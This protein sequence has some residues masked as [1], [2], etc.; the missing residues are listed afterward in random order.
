MSEQYI[1]FYYPR[2]GII[3]GGAQLLYA[4]II[5]YISKNTKL[6]IRLYDYENGC[7]RQLLKN[8]NVNNYE[9]NIIKNDFS[10]L[11]NGG[12]E[13]FVIAPCYISYIANGLKCNNNVRFIFWDLLYPLWEDLISI[14]FKREKIIS[15]PNIREK[16]LITMIN[17]H[18][19]AILPEGLNYFEKLT[20]QQIEED[21]ILNVPIDG[22]EYKYKPITK[23][24]LRIT[25]LG[26]SE[27]WKISPVRKI[28]KDLKYYKI[29]FTMNIITDN[30][31]LFKKYLKEECNE[32]IISFK[33]NLFGKELYDFILNNTDIGFGMGTSALE[34]A[35]LGIPTI[36]ADSSHKD[37]PIN[38][39]YQWL[40][41]NRGR[42]LGINID[43]DKWNGNKSLKEIVN[44]FQYDFSNK[45]G[46]NCYEYVKKYNSIKVIANKLI[47]LTQKTELTSN[48][49]NNWLLKINYLKRK[50][51]LLFNHKH[52]IL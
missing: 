15:F 19:F 52:N 34:F 12:N 35:K 36:L 33:Q 46:Q 30:I 11:E 4:R 10:K 7:L 24:S 51:G 6:H 2:K 26:R 8:L 18:G 21:Y 25:Y 16:I 43:L 42:G 1:S 39:K 37:F 14:K 48:D 40:Y 22:I 44:E 41:T 28:L 27:F 13:V 3:L 31:N 50:L 9:L 29:N 17:K 45:I 5:E 47:A 20:K 38:Y 23:N 49:F 32:T